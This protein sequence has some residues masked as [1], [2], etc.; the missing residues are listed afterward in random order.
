MNAYILRRLFPFYI[1]AI[2]AEI[3]FSILSILI[4]PETISLSFGTIV[5]GLGILLLTTTSAFL[6][7]M[8]PYVIYFILLP[9]KWQNN[10]FDKITTLI[11]FVL[12]TTITYGEEII[13]AL[14][15]EGYFSH[16]SL[17]IKETLSYLS[18]QSTL[19]SGLVLL[20]AASCFIAHRYLIPDRQSPKII[21]R[22]F[23]GIIYGLVCSLTF[24]NI[25]QDTLRI[26]QDQ[27]T[28]HLASEGTYD[29]LKNSVTRY[30]HDILVKQPS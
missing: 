13:S 4:S 17:N 10:K 7:M 11:F 8:I 22:L 20:I 15:G 16:D 24:L 12:Y 23:Q 19:L 18:S 21:N 28:N 27:Y 3:A 9:Q 26:S 2:I 6:I 25:N 29:L 5:K 30:G 14:F 1:F